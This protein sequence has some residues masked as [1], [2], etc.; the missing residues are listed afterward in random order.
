MEAGGSELNFEIQEQKGFSGV[1]NAARFHWLGNLLAI[2]I[3]V[4]AD[5]NIDRQWANVS[6]SIAGDPIYRNLPDKP[7]TAGVIVPGLPRLGIWI[8]PDNKSSGELED[9]IFRMIPQPDPVW[10]R[11]ER[12]VDDIPEDARRFPP[13]KALRA[14][15]HA[16]MATRERPRPMWAGIS[17][18]DLVP[19]E[20]SRAFLDWL[21][22]LF[23]DDIP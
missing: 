1:L 19:D 5:D 2:G 17:A 6:R 4:D 11:S 18:K 15:V 23:G 16:W 7:E 12:Y 21:R 10:P 3:V 22:R 9:F 8:W 14:K 13:H 20:N